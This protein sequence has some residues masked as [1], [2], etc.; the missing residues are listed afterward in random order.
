MSSLQ[1]MLMT[2]HQFLLSPS[3]RIIQDKKKRN[4][5]AHIFSLQKNLLYLAKTLPTPHARV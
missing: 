2:Q 5:A 4:G 1:M 3:L